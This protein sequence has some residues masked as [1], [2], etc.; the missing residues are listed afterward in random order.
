MIL[1]NYRKR[2]TKNIQPKSRQREKHGRQIMINGV[3]LPV[4]VMLAV[5]VSF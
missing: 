5:F 3:I 2:P 4:F 1:C